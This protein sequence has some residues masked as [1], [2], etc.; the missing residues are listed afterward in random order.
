MGYTRH[1]KLYGKT[2]LSQVAGKKRIFNKRS[3]SSPR[4]SPL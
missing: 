4:K 3:F 2:R 1:N